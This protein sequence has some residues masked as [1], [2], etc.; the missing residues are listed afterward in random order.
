MGKNSS[1]QFSDSHLSI[2]PWHL[3]SAF[4]FPIFKM[5]VKTDSKCSCT[6]SEKFILTF[7]SSFY[8]DFCFWLLLFFCGRDGGIGRCGYVGRRRFWNGWVFRGMFS[9]S[10]LG[11]AIQQF[12]IPWCCCGTEGVANNLWLNRRSKGHIGSH[13]ILKTFVG[14]ETVTGVGKEGKCGIFSHSPAFVV[15]AFQGWIS[16]PF[17]LAG[18]LLTI[19]RQFQVYI[20]IYKPELH[21]LNVTIW[22]GSFWCFQ[23]VHF[24][25]PEPICLKYS[26]VMYSKSPC[27][28][29]NK[30]Y[31]DMCPT[32]F[33][34]AL[35]PSNHK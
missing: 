3:W 31:S 22:L 25:K 11:G 4:G 32:L 28:D 27:H 6:I 23:I 16:Q 15:P 12:V 35:L 33:Y 10:W 18:W 9:F 2:S 20:Y 30:D 13:G 24:P 5:L 34:V 29:L 26:S 7:F 1:I 8:F 17:A 14:I 19:P 21:N